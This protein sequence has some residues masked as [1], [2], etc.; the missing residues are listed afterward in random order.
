MPL[1]ILDKIFKENLRFRVLSKKLQHL[2]KFY[3]NYGK[4]KKD[5]SK[6]EY[7]FKEIL[8]IF[9]KNVEKIGKVRHNQ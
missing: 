7:N 5:L 2:G 6:V 8:G 3:E 4:C 9:R 1:K